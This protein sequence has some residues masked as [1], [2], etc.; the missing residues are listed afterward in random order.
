MKPILT[1]TE[2]TKQNSY[3]VIKNPSY[4]ERKR[5]TFSKIMYPVTVIPA[6]AWCINDAVSSGSSPD[7]VK[8]SVIVGILGGTVLWFAGN[9]I[10]TGIFGPRK[11]N[12]P[13][14]EYE[15]SEWLNKYNKKRNKDLL[16]VSFNNG[17]LTTLSPNSKNTFL[18]YS[19]KDFKN[20]I[21]LFPN[22]I[23]TPIVF[24][25]ALPHLSRDEVMEIMKLYPYDCC[26]EVAQD[27]LLNK[28][29]TVNEYGEIS[30]KYTR[31]Y[32]L[33]EEK[34]A[35]SVKN[36]QDVINYKYY[37]NESTNTEK[38]ISNIVPKLFRYEL[39]QLIKLYPNVSTIDQAK[40]TFIKESNSFD[41]TLEAISKYNNHKSHGAYPLA[42]F[43]KSIDQQRIFVRMYP[44]NAQSMTFIRNI[45]DHK[46]QMKKK[47]NSFLV[48]DQLEYMYLDDVEPLFILSKLKQIS[49]EYPEDLSDIQLS[50]LKHVRFV[51]T[52]RTVQNSKSGGIATF[53]SGTTFSH[54]SNV[55]SVYKNE[56]I[57]VLNPK[58]SVG[59][60]DDYIS[61]INNPKILVKSIFDEDNI[62]GYGKWGRKVYHSDVGDYDKPVLVPSYARSQGE[63]LSSGWYIMGALTGAYYT[64]TKGLQY[65]ASKGY[66]S[67][68]SSGREYTNELNNSING[69]SKS[70]NSASANK[71]RDVEKNNSE[72]QIIEDGTHRYGS[73]T[74]VKYKIICSNG[75]KNLIFYNEQKRCWMKTS[76]AFCDYSSTKG[77]EGLKKSAKILCGNN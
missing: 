45:E 21:R 22:S 8:G 67:S 56:L 17:I 58:E 25:S 55:G 62:P 48:V 23:H 49:N 38:M 66:I 29:N 18:A 13:K 12:A 3:T 14:N 31:L 60:F 59:G 39:P 16:L 76:S 1:L 37:F 36:M 24:K 54:K 53:F 61:P 69:S 64:Y 63:S 47:A 46:H 77:Q 6:T 52:T 2:N 50:I 20:Y 68:S 73:Y 44:N 43:S 10:T 30:R 35:L 51:T 72:L 70:P 34:A 26:K 65:A 9:W 28:S 71:K 33:A 74:S 5:T 42:K 32:D 4:S 27:A 7:G 19:V 57:W 41:G 75:H 11:K 15:A 40:I